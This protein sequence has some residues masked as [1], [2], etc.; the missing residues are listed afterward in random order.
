MD[1]EKINEIKKLAII[2]MFSDDDLMERLVLKGG[3]ALDIVYKVESRAS[4]DLDF[5][6]P[7]EFKP[8]EVQS[9]GLKLE[10]SLKRVFNENGYEVFDINFEERPK[11]RNEKTP[12]FWGGYELNFKVIERNTFIKN[13]ADSQQ[14]RLS[15]ID[16]GP[17]SRKTFRVDISKWEDCHF[18]TE[19][20]LDDYTIYLYTPK[21]IVFEKLRAI[22]Q[23]MPK[24][25]NFIG[26]HDGIARARVFFDIY[27]TVKH[28]GLDLTDEE[29]LELLRNIFKAKECR[30]ELLMEAC[31]YREFHRP[32]FLQ[33]VNTVKPKVKLK[34]F[35][36]YFDY[37]VTIC[38]KLAKAL[39]IV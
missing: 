39:R 11:E 5:S 38:D 14:L 35:D 20:E 23:Q 21:A 24:Y 19:A 37:V 32:D 8:N 28:F 15:A 16:I 36:F 29:S 9:I 22:C 12:P 30:L 1:L 2:A 10:A 3:N 18:K 7:S 31:N 4:L 17:G 26:T 25:C 27:T 34:E 6:M 13:I 33:V